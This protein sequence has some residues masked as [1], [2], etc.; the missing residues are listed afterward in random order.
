M[1]LSYPDVCMSTPGVRDRGL[2]KTY[3]M[4]LEEA[5]VI[6]KTKDVY[7]S[8]TPG[9]WKRRELFE[10]TE[11]GKVL[12]GLFP[13]AFDIEE[14]K[15]LFLPRPGLFAVLN[16]LQKCSE[17]EDEWGTTTFSFLC[18]R[19]PRYDSWT[20]VGNRKNCIRYLKLL[21]AL[22]WLEKR[23]NSILD[24]SFYDLSGEGELFLRSFP[25]A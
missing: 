5:Q 2:M 7:P 22:G 14:A 8:K 21:V 10:I 23:Y 3:L 18:H 9:I 1:S 11:K 16:I 19:N 25:N 4:F 15:K 13:Q 20:I 6:R 12:F 17:N 24:R